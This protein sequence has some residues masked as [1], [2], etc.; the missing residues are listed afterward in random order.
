MATALQGNHVETTGLVGPTCFLLQKILGGKHQFLLFAGIDAGQCSAKARV[1]PVTDFDEYYCIAVKHDQ[2]K[3]TAFAAPVLRQQLQAL[4]LE[5]VQGL[6]FGRISG[7]LA[8]AVGHQRG[9]SGR[10]LT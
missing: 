6:Q 7:G 10:R 4:R 5:V 9:V 8:R 3:L 2:I 1:Q